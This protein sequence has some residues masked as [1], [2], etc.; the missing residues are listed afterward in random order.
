MS[1]CI[2]WQS[3]RKLRVCLKSQES[4][5]KLLWGYVFESRIGA[6]YPCCTAY[7]LFFSK[8]RPSRL[9]AYCDIITFWIMLLSLCLQLFIKVKEIGISQF[10]F[11]ICSVRFLPL[12]A[13]FSV[14][15]CWFSISVT[16]D[17]S[18]GIRA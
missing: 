5:F 14:K 1:P 16:V 18:N 4:S 13:V 6:I 2:K 8:I 15:Q 9:V 3:V 7:I 11:I 10:T 12:T 17:S